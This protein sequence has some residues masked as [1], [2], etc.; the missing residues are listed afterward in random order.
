MRS[1]FQ[2]LGNFF[3]RLFSGSSA[4]PLCDRCRWDYGD[5]CRRPERPNATSCEDFKAR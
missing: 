4:A 5:A 3:R 2:A 1:L